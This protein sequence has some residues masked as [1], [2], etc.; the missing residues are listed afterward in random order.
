[1]KKLRLIGIV[2]ALMALGTLA[3]LAGEVIVRNVTTTSSGE[4]QHT[5]GGVLL[6]KNVSSTA[7]GGVLSVYHDYMVGGVAGVARR[8]L[9]GGNTVTVLTS[10]VVSDLPADVYVLPGQKITL[11]NSTA[12]A[13]HTVYLIL[14]RQ[15]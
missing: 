9:H 11:T 15:E 13:S 10:R 2:L 6:L 4:W 3:T 14:E 7:T 1:M 8:A 12:I 5:G